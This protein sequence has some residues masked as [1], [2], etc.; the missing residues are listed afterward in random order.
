MRFGIRLPVVGPFASKDTLTQISMLVDDLGF[1]SVWSQ[2]H[3]IWTKQREELAPNVGAVEAVTSNMNPN[4]FEYYTLTPYI[5]ALTRRIRFGFAV[6]MMP[7]VHPIITAKLIA[8]MDVLSEGRIIF[9]IAA[10]GH[11]SKPTFDAL[12]IDFEKRSEITDEYVEAVQRLWTEDNC[13][14][15]GRF[16]KFSNVSLY[17]RTI[18]KPHPPIWIAGNTYRYVKRAAKYGSGLMLTSVDP[19]SLEEIS[20]WSNYVRDLRGTNVKDFTMDMFACL[21]S[22]DKEA[23]DLAHT[24]LKQRV[25]LQAKENALV[26]PS[27]SRMERINLI[28]SPST[29]IG[30]VKEYEKAGV[31]LLEMRFIS[32]THDKM[33]EMIKRFSTEVIPSI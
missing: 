27:I 2:G 32:T 29:I 9:C 7:F 22:T 4:S 17:P 13:S 8:D 20:Q 26:P 11:L 24:T 6:Y 21:A 28:G 33:V 5:A 15:N 31:N 10:A 3:L 30:K 16:V 1:H 23:S 18:Q 12:G 14:F 25:E 19:R